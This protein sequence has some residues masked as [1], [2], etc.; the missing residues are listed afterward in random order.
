MLF[1]LLFVGCQLSLVGVCLSFVDRVV[2][3][4][5]VVCCWLFG[6]GCSCFRSL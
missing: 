5:V 1:V 2:L 3:L 6:G 4:F